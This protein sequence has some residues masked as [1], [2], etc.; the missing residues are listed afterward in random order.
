MRVAQLRHELYHAA[1][2]LGTAQAIASGD[3]VKIERR[4]VSI[5]LWRIIG[6]CFRALWHLL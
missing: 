3:P 5:M 6:R 4:A 1:S 2:I